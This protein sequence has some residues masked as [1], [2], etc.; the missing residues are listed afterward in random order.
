MVRSLGDVSLTNMMDLS[1]GRV[2][3]RVIVMMDWVD[4]WLDVGGQYRKNEAAMEY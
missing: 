3:L 4:G 2:A 1:S